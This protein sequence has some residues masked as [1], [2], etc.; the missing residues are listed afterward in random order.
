MSDKHDHDHEGHD[1]KHDHDHPGHEHGEI[2]LPVREKPAPAA[3]PDPLAD[4]AVEDAGTQA[5]SDALRSSFAIVKVLMVV[6]V[7]AFLGSG[8]F[9]VS[10]Q[11]RAMILRFGKP[12][13]VGADQLLGPGL[14]WSWPA[15]ID[16]IVRIPISEYQVARS[17]AG[18]YATTPEAEAANAE[19]GPNPSLSP[20]ADGYTITSDGNIIHV[21]AEIRYRITDPLKYELGFTA[22]SNVVVNILDEALFFASSQFTVDQA[23][24]QNRLGFQEK[25][26]AR[27][28]QRV[29]ELGLGITVE[30][31][32]VRVIPPRQTK[33]AF[34]S[35]L[36]AEIERRKALDDARSYAGRVLSTADGEANSVINAGQTD[37][38]RLEQAIAAEAQYYTNQLPFYRDNSQLFMDLRQAEVLARVMTNATK[39]FVPQPSAGK[40]REFR[41]QLNRDPEKPVAPQDQQQ[42]PQNR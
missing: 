15:P 23:L 40:Q 34:D 35:A 33:G 11:E 19:P 39:W 41:L 28:R 37:K 30:P 25:I 3:T 27:V 9:T 4:R 26:L 2:K 21:R 22:S 17:T 7:L 1:H 20:G 14:H 13:G 5:L 31:G 36:A 42:P 18:W 29:E 16:E 10:S 6:L 38:V 8:I 24:T 32:D 12:V